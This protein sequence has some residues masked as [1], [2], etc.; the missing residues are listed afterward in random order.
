M[1]TACGTKIVHTHPCFHFILLC[2]LGHSL[3]RRDFG[4][5]TVCTVTSFILQSLE[6]TRIR[7][8]PRGAFCPASAGRRPGPAY[9]GRRG[10]GAP[11]RR[12]APA[13]SRKDD[14]LTLAS[15]LG[16]AAE[17]VEKCL[18][19]AQVCRFEAFGEPP[20]RLRQQ[21]ACFPGPSLPAPEPTQAHG[22][23]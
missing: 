7:Q 8:P 3:L 18:R 5:M 15:A 10:G 4:H 9:A 13:T 21:P 22:D 23:T 1:D 12:R 2:A 14:R 20:V 6:P 19:L 17:L 16:T 11:P